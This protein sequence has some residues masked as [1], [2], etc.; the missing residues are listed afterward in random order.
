MKQLSIKWSLTAA[1]ALLVVMIGLIS[2]LGFYTNTTSD[3][4][5]SEINNINVRLANLANR[6]QVNALRAQTFLDR[7][8]SF[9][10]Q[11]NPDKGQESLAMAADAVTAA[12]SRF[13][14]FSAIPVTP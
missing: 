5:L 8:A 13:D 12:Q 14:E 11:G 7:S 3:R 2:A 9:S 1:L 10:T 6:T 4:A